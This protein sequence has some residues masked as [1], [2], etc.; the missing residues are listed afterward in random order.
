MSDF[1]ALLEYLGLTPS[2]IVPLVL[3][4][5]VFS[6]AYWKIIVQPDRREF[7][8]AKQELTDL[9]N[10]AKE[11]QMHLEKDISFT[12]QHS[13][14][15]KT[16][17]EQYGVHGS[18]MRPS[19]KGRKLL[20]DSGFNDV[21]PQI[22]DK[23]FEQMDKMKLRTA[24]DYEA[25]ASR[26]LLHLSNDPLID[27]L[28]DYAVNHPEESLELIFGVASWVIRDDYAKYLKDKNEQKTL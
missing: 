27:R 6:I 25:G 22:K 21:Y 7:S 3:V 18:P 12:P 2:Q 14:E 16:I 24:Y 8:K 26:A 17:F 13:L 5:S 19:D 9:H 4:A 20:E 1:L 23:I 10:A 11:L 15:Q 28:K